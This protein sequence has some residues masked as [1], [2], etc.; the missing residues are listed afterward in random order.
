MMNLEPPPKVRKLQDTLHA[1]A[2]RSPDYRFYLLYDKVYRPDILAFAYQRSRANRGAP[3]VDHQTFGD[4][5]SYGVE[6]WLSELAQE[7]RTRQYRP[8]P[9]HRVY[10]P[11][12]DG[13]QRPLGIPTVKDRVVQTAA[14]LVLEPIF[15]AD[16]Q[17]E[18]YAYRPAR[19]ALDAV[20]VVRQMLEDGHTQVVDADLTG[21]FDSIPHRE[22]MKSVARRV[23]DRHLL[24]L[25]KMWLK[26]PIH[27]SRK[28][29]DGPK[30]RS[31]DA[32]D[33]PRGTPQGAPLSPLLSN[34]YMRRFILAW[35]KWGCER[36]LDAHIVNY[37]DDFVICC[38]GTADLA[39]AMMQHIM[40][41][42]KLTVNETK[43]HLRRLPDET[44]DFLGYTFGRCYSFKTGQPYIGMS[45]SKKRMQRFCRSLTE[46]LGRDTTYREVADT[47]QLLNQKLK[48]W[49]N[50]YCLGALDRSYRVIDGH[51]ADR[52]CRWLRGKLA[53]TAKRASRMP[54]VH[55]YEHY[56]LI[57]LQKRRRNVSWATA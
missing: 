51:V 4:I 40:T 21:Y 33:Q 30:D 24:H 38:R 43:T 20:K 23:S 2:K 56:G 36:D 32:P 29:D 50:Y 48:G 14:M 27:E 57:E 15:E 3:G 25:V 5:E 37:A 45:P 22:L 19:G 13:G 42:L 17:P 1:K 55:L 16:L 41:R 35:K 52:L 7:L 53:W 11:K 47:I 31:G 49:A 26:A 9:V 6:Q 44:F 54:T 8:Q 28:G 10:I 12:P 46:A 34:L 18:Q 39:M